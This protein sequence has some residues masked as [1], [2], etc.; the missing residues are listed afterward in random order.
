M[1]LLMIIVQESWKGVFI[2]MFSS[3]FDY[4]DD[5]GYPDT[6]PNI[7]DQRGLDNW[8]STVQINYMCINVGYVQVKVNYIHYDC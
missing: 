4:L 3:D 2:D 5:F 7:R 8:G 6:W 1:L